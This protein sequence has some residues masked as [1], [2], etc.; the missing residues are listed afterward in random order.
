M[1]NKHTPTPW[2]IKGNIICGNTINTHIGFCYRLTTETNPDGT[3]KDCEIEK[4]NREFIVTACNNYYAL[5]S[6]NTLLK[7][8]NEA[9]IFTIEK[10]Q[11]ENEEYRAMLE[12]IRDCHNADANG[13]LDRGDTTIC[14]YHSNVA[15]QINNLLTK[16]SK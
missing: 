12:L 14:N 7:E 9:Q 16:H 13:A 4:A 2:V 6:D 3:W 8:V 11:K 10:Y 5:K 1:E 15:T